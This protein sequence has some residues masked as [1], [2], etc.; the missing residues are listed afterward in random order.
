LAASCKLRSGSGYLRSLLTW[1]LAAVLLAAC[2]RGPVDRICTPLDVGDLAISEIRPE[3]DDAWGQWFEL[4]NPTGQTLELT[5]LKLRIMS[6]SG[7]GQQDIV[8]R[9][10]GL[11]V[12]AQGYFGLGRFSVGDQPAHVDYGYAVD[13]DSDLHSQHYENALVQILSCNPSDP[14][15]PGLDLVIDQV[16]YQD[17]PDVGSLGFDG[18]L[19]L[20]AE[21]NDEESDWCTDSSMVEVEIGG[22]T[23]ELA[24]G[25]PGAVNRACP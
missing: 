21:S 18:A 19:A 12:G 9:A 14:E 2:Q 24:A 5:G 1:S 8:L 7:A 6:F 15:D 25:T 16:V 4:Y 13:F 10:H 23:V 11:Q 17:L 22:A 20:T 3:Q